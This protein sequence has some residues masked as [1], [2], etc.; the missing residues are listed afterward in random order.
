MSSGIFRPAACWILFAALFYAPWAYGGTTVESIATI[1]CL[2]AAALLFWIVDLL[3]NR[4][5]PGFPRALVVFIGLLLALGG[6]MVF[7]ASAISDS[8]F[9]AFA[10]LPKPAPNFPGSVDYAL[11]A[12][13]M[14]RG[15][16]LLGVVLF[17]VDLSREDRWLLRLWYAVALA[18]GSV[19]LLGV[20]QKA[21]GARMIFWR[22]APF[23]AITTF[24]AAYYY[25]GNAGAY[26]NLVLPLT[27]GLAVRSFVTP[28]KAGMRALWSIIFV[29]TL[30]A[31]FANTSRMAQSIAVLSLIAMVVL[32]GPRLLR[33][34]SRTEKNIALAGVGA[35]LLAVFAV[36]Q[37]TH[38]EQPIKRWERLSEHIASDA[39]WSSATVA[40]K[41]AIP[42]AGLLGFGP[43][44]FRA[45]FPWFNM[46]APAPAPGGWR[47]L[48]N[49]YLQT[50]IEWGWLGAAL[51]A[52]IFFC[53]L[54]L[55]VRRL[56]SPDARAWAPRRR[57]MLPLAVVALAGVALH[58]T[59]DF[60][61]Q[62]ASI[63][64]YAAVY[65]GLC[66]GSTRWRSGR[67]RSEKSAPLTD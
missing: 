48:H 57:L 15:A 29:V 28:T 4:R 66:W 53:G 6:W 36:A 5:P 44:T 50:V 24:F 61:L 19:A 12:A 27:T 1:N 14:I 55:A 10:R 51:W 22:P 58:A 30:V 3:V 21:T 18:G 67:V 56:R 38:L 2:L 31:V 9:D 33:R 46:S 45:V 49:D 26:L 13:W 17:I 54:T 41:Q 37:A 23:E 32:L 16:L 47:F 40:L 62:I 25:H 7:N 20:L 35:M 63:Q 42:E 34:F 59:V 11:S 60:P 65:L 52:L 43:G 39:R 64:L 8:T